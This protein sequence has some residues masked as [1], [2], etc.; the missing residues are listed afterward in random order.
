MKNI[1]ILSFLIIGI[2]F[3]ACTGKVQ[4]NPIPAKEKIIFNNKEIKLNNKISKKLINRFNKF[5]DREISNIK[6]YNHKILYNQYE[7]NSPNIGIKIN[8]QDKKVSRNTD[9]KNPDIW[10]YAYKKAK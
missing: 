5:A 3:S 10:E 4:T 9:D 2:V 1:K 6:N 7:D 8:G